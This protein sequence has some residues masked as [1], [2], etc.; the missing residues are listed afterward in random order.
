MEKDYYAEEIENNTPVDYFSK[1]INVDSKKIE[2]ENKTK[3][4]ITGGSAILGGS[5]AGGYGLLKSFYKPA[6]QIRKKEVLLDDIKKNYLNEPFIASQD[7]PSR[8][9]SKGNIAIQGLRTQ[10][11]EGKVKLSELKLGQENIKNNLKAD[12]NNF[13]KNIL[14][15][16][17]EETADGFK[18][19]APKFFNKTYE[20][21]GN[22]LNQIESSLEKQGKVISTNSFVNEV[23]N[24]TEQDALAVGVP[25]DKLSKISD[26]K[27]MLCQGGE[28]PTTIT[29]LKGSIGFLQNDIPKEALFKLKEN[30]GTYLEKNFPE[31]GE[32]LSSINKDYRQVALMRNAI[33]KTVD[34]NTGMFDKTKLNRM[35]GMYA[36]SKVQTGIEDT[37]KL[38]AEGNNIATG[39][40]DIG[41]IFSKLKEAKGKR[42]GIETA[43]EKALQGS[44]QGQSDVVS[45]L[46]SIH[47][48]IEDTKLNTMKWADKA[49]QIL[50]EQKSIATKHPIRSGSVGKS[51]QRGAMVG[52]RAAIASLARKT[53]GMMGV[54]PIISGAVKFINDPAVGWG[55]QLGVSI[56]KKG[57]VDRSVLEK[58]INKTEYPEEMPKISPEEEFNILVKYGL[59]A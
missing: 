56:P 7:V 28:K 43:A 9:E 30:W 59:G 5:V 37:V 39:H 49:D 20:N 13:D 42:I 12:L 40:G 44:V 58:F 55:E 31:A 51:L 38:M 35:L 47:K 10:E 18:E 15:K 57:T 26:L 53:I 45:R 21:Y 8:I 1:E 17:I 34:P 50:S 22:A 14:S 29:Q 54:V 3:K 36:K 19:I 25:P 27:N 16:T 4:L 46:S 24:K 41:K 6:A 23:L 52:E 11:A 32:A 2:K 33:Y 48:Q